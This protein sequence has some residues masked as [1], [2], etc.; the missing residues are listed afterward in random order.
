MIE[1]DPYTVIKQQGYQQTY[2]SSIDNLV[3]D[4]Y[5]FFTVKKILSV[6]SETGS[7]VKSPVIDKI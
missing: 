3:I 6:V 1:S 4:D 5:G 7:F 2:D